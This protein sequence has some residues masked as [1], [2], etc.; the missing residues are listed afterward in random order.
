M[1]NEYKNQ[2]DGLVSAITKT[3]SDAVMGALSAQW[4]IPVEN[5][6]GTVRNGAGATK[7]HKAKAGKTSK[8][9]VKQASSGH[10]GKGEKR[11]PALLEELTNTLAAHVKANPGMRVEE[12]GQ[13]LGYPTKA[14]AL[15]MKKLLSIKT[16]RAEGVKRAT[17]YFPAG[18]RVKAIKAKPQATA[19]AA[20]VAKKRPPG[21]KPAQA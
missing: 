15:P 10:Q 12:I 4:G 8:P 20:R 11:S 21:V 14:L 16:V 5:V 3:V 13:A 1:S 7:S 17:R 2:V 18:G 6:L 9:V 19:K